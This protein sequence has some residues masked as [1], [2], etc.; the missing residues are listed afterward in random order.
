MSNVIDAEHRVI[1]SL[2]SLR[3]PTRCA[4]CGEWIADSEHRQPGSERVRCG[5]CCPVCKWY[6]R[7][8]EEVHAIQAKLNRNEQYGPMTFQEWV[9]LVQ[10]IES[11]YNDWNE[12]MERMEQ[13]IGKLCLA[14]GLDWRELYCKYRLKKPY[15]LVANAQ[16][17][18][19][20]EED[21]EEPEEPDAD[22]QITMQ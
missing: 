7:P 1:C 20:E 11:L 17:S 18:P 13:L 3:G 16:Y 12:V 8:P 2:G 14:H 15:E 10:N 6:Y 9:Y 19:S 4:D 5:R 21:G 22:E